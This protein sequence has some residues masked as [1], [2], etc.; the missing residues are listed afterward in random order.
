MFSKLYIPY[1]SFFG[2]S[3]NDDFSVS[4]YI[5]PDDRNGE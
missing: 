3:F 1:N 4:C 2:P 5:M